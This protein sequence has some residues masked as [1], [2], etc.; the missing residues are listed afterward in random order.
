[1]SV[2]TYRSLV[3]VEWLG[4][5]ARGGRVA[6][7][8]A[9]FALLA[10]ACTGSLRAAVVRVMDLPVGARVY[11]PVSGVEW[12]V[13]DNNRPGV[14]AH[15]M[16][17]MATALVASRQYNSIWENKWDIAT[18]RTYLN[19]TFF[20]SLSPLFQAVTV[21]TQVPWL[22]NVYNSPQATGV[23][24]DRVYLPSVTEL[25]GTADPDEGTVFAWFA[26]PLTAAAR[27]STIGAGQSPSSVYWTRTG[28][29][30]F[31]STQYY[32]L[33]ASVVT[34]DTGSL[35]FN[36]WVTD[37]NGIVPVLNISGGAG[38]A[39][40]GDGRYVITS[41]PEP[42]AALAA[43]LLAGGGLLLR[44]RRHEG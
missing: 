23:T 3:S 35:S 11:E 8:A 31:W 4:R 19:T 30:S 39:L 38:V 16:T 7:G 9:G 41:I 18:A 14:P 13:V 12:L 2:N 28:H 34:R 6:L 32:N 26:D 5:V 36:S 43:L 22:S 21:E 24:T 15:S 1:M 20:N 37:S 27:R 17:L 10:M 25:G 40:Q 42:D 44:K 33:S 29:P